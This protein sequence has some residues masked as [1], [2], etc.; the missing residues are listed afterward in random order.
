VTVRELSA[1]AI[2]M[3]S[4]NKQLFLVN[5]MGVGDENVFGGIVELI[6]AE[7]A[8]AVYGG[9]VAADVGEELAVVG[10]AA[11]VGAVTDEVVCLP[12][13]SFTGGLR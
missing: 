2:R 8:A 9:V 4:N 12:R 7:Q 11:L 13:S 3:Y 10:P 5:C 1:T 6:G